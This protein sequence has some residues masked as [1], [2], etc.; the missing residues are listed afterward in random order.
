MLGINR[1][2]FETRVGPGTLEGLVIVGKTTKG[3][4]IGLNEE[5]TGLGFPFRFRVEATFPWVSVF[6]H[7]S[8][9]LERLPAWFRKVRFPEHS[10]FNKVDPQVLSA[11]F[12][13]VEF[14]EVKV[15]FD[16]EKTEIRKAT[17]IGEDE[18]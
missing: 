18:A 1:E 11:T 7:R 3:Q 13:K 9:R 5:S 17:L 6:N 12:E 2:Q 10:I 8:E 16:G 4:W 14:W 15:A